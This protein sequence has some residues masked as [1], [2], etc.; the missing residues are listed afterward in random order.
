M[1]AKDNIARRKLSLLDLAN[2]LSNV[3]S[4]CRVMGCSRQQFYEV[5]RHAVGRNAA[6]CVDRVNDRQ[7]PS[8]T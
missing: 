3:S 5:R 6:I 1:T 2:E 8:H 7:Q 4:A